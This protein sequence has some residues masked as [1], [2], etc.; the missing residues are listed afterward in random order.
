MNKGKQKD[1][2]LIMGA[3]YI[4]YSDMSK[5]GKVTIE[6]NAK[7]DMEIYTEEFEFDGA[8]SC[9]QHSAKAVAWARDLLD[10]ALKADQLLPGG[11]SAL[12]IGCD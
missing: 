6:L 3:E 2:G 4:D 7:G 12:T 10:T 9:R 5:F 8:G 1:H 11:V